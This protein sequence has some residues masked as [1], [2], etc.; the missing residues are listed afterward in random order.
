MKFPLSSKIEATDVYKADIYEAF[1]YSGRK[2]DFDNPTFVPTLAKKRVVCIAYKHY[3]IPIEYCQ[4]LFNRLSL[5]IA[6]KNSNMYKDPRFL[7]T[8]PND[9]IEGP[10]YYVEN[11]EQLFDET[12]KKYTINQLNNLQEIYRSANTNKG[13][14]QVFIVDPTKL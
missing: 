4:T 1:D 7:T 9:E 5:A 8:E 10:K 3:L 11:V 14:R 12:S 2:T 6:M 13:K